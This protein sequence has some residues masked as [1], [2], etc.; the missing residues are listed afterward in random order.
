MG[1]PYCSTKL[2]AAMALRRESVPRS[3]SPGEHNHA[4][5]VEREVLTG[6]DL[7]FDDRDVV[8]RI[9]DDGEFAKR[10]RRSLILGHEGLQTLRFYPKPLCANLR[11]TG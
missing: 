3:H 6:F 1:W 4:S 7:R 11:A 8:A 5:V 9:D 10:S 2:S